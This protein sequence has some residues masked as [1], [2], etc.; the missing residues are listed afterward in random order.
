MALRITN[1]LTNLLEKL[2]DLL[3]NKRRGDWGDVAIMIG[4]TSQQNAEKSFKRVFSKNHKKAVEA[5]EKIIN[6]RNQLL[7]NWY[8]EKVKEDPTTVLQLQNNWS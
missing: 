3:K 1:T 6:T 5:L 4:A 8:Y 2:N 7:N